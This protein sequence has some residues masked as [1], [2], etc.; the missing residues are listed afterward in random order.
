VGGLALLLEILDIFVS[1]HVD[2]GHL[3]EFLR[4][5]FTVRLAAELQNLDGNTFAVEFIVFNLVRVY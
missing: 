3:F 1:N 2:Q 4:L 5:Q